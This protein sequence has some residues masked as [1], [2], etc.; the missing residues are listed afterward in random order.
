MRHVRA[1]PDEASSRGRRARAD[2]LR[3]HEP[4]IA[5]NAMAARLARSAGMPSPSAAD[6]LDLTDLER[7]LRRGP[8]AAVGAGATPRRAL[9]QAVLR[10]LRPY[11]AHQRMVDEELVRVLRTLDER[12]RGAVAG[13]QALAAE[14][15]AHEAAEDE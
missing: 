10:V 3:T 4:H 14:L 15:R 13:Q 2:I 5:G 7:R 6:A 11:S 8:E 9:R 12:V 1:H